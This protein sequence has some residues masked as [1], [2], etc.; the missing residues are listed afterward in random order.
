[1]WILVE[2]DVAVQKRNYQGVAQALP[3]VGA[4]AL[5]GHMG[6]V[7]GQ[8]RSATCT[9]HGNSRVIVLS[10]PVFQAVMADPG[11]AG[12]LF[13]RLLIA[14]M[15]RQLASGNAE[16]RRLLHPEEVARRPAAVTEEGLVAAE[17]SFEGWKGHRSR[18]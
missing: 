7:D 5:L 10:Q 1:M 9:A 8:P 18:P 13:R 12:D 4:P 11:P 17:A 3:E 15:N 16:L 6:M 2:G 14:G